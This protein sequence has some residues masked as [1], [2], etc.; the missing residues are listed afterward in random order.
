MATTSTSEATERYVQLQDVKA[1]ILEAGTG[2]PTICIH[3][4][5]FTSSAENWLPAIRAGLAR[6]LHLIAVDNIGW[7]AGDRPTFEY[8][9]R[10]T[11]LFGQPSSTRLGILDFSAELP[12]AITRKLFVQIT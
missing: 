5:G 4:V 6:N 12:S 2:T 7:G 9:A 11:R 10:N 8:S 3:G 1:R